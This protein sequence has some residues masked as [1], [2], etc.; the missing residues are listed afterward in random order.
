MRRYPR[1]SSVAEQMLGTIRIAAAITGVPES[2]LRYWEHVK[3]LRPA[4]SAGGHRQYSSE[5][6]ALILEIKRLTRVEGR[7][8][9]WMRTNWP[10]RAKT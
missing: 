9:R 8:M 2:T 3:L 7:S 4:R 10:G 6:L 5:D 1:G